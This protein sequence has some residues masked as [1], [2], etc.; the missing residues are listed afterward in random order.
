MLSCAGQVVFELCVEIVAIFL[1]CV[2][3]G[4]KGEVLSVLKVIIYIEK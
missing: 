2:V 1:G 3:S 4:R